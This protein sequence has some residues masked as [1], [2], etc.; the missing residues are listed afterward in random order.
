MRRRD[1]IVGVAGA[2]AWSLV[3]RAQQPRRVGVL[4]Q[5]GAHL[6][7]LA[8]L[9]DALSAARPGGAEATL[10][11]REGKGDVGV[12]EGAARD[13]ESAGV[14][15]VVAFA[16]SVAIAAE[17]ATSRVPIVFVTGS[18]PVRFGLVESIARPGGRITGVHSLFTDLTAKRL[19]LLQEMLPRARRVVSFYSATNAGGKRAVEVAAETSRL[20]GLD[21]VAQAANSPEEVRARVDALAAV[22][23]DAYFFV[24]DSLILAHDQ[25]VVDAANRIGM[26]TMS[27]ELDVVARGAL[28]GYG[29]NY[30]ELGRNAGELV[31]RI[32]NGTPAHELP[33]QASTGI[34][35]AINL[36]TARALGLTIPPTVLARADEVIE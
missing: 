12:L 10:L 7:G 26:A 18:D 4:L 33:V 27:H 13:L 5:G 19:A 35:L 11:V 1:A 14:D 32:L 17:R 9:R 3:A 28:A 25:L 8:G 22:Q 24:P 15:V 30:R 20:L 21:F 29:P 34:A 36:K 2:A 23:A 16:I 31:I 6:A